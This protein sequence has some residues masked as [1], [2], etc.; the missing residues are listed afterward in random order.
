[1]PYSR[2]SFRLAYFDFIAVITLDRIGISLPVVVTDG[3]RGHRP[4]NKRRNTSDSLSV[5]TRNVKG[6]AN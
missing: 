2:L 3:L 1:M 4:C 6:Q 5:N